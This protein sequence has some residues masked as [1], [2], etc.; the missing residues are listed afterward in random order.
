[1][2]LNCSDA[3]DVTICQEAPYKAR[4]KGELTHD[5]KWRLRSPEITGLPPPLSKQV[6]SYF[7]NV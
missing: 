6:N 4:P 5:L 1:M 3:E 7:S 2:T